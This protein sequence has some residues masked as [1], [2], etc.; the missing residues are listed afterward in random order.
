MEV[1]RCSE[2]S[3]QLTNRHSLEPPADAGS[4]LIFLPWKWR[5]YIPP[6]RLFNSQDLHGATSQKTAFFIVTVVKTSNLTYFPASFIIT[7]SEEKQ[8][9]SMF[10][11]VNKQHLIPHVDDHESRYEGHATEH[12]FEHFLSAVSGLFNWRPRVGVVTSKLHIRLC[13]KSTLV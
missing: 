10:Y 12:D 4:S 8:P 1:I 13:K 11:R 9:L 3:V 5:R 2:T 6:K 7:N